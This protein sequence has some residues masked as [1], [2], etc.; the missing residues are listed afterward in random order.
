MR[1]PGHAAQRLERGAA[2]REPLVVAP[3][4]RFVRGLDAERPADALDSIA[5]RRRK[6]G[7]DSIVAVHQQQVAVLGELPQVPLVVRAE[8]AEIA[9]QEDQAAGARDPREPLQRSLGVGLERLGG[10]RRVPERLSVL[11]VCSRRSAA[12]E[13]SAGRNS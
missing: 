10:R 1:I 3:A 5:A 8:P 12:R 2:R 7:L 6:F 9:E 13:P 4:H 11:I